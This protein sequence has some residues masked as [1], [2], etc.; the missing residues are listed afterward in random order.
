MPAAPANDVSVDSVV[1]ALVREHLTN[2]EFTSTLT[3][4][5]QEQPTVQ[6]PINKRSILHDVLGLT[7]AQSAPQSRHKPSTLDVLVQQHLL[8][9]QHAP[10]AP[11]SSSKTQPHAAGGL[12]FQNQALATKQQPPTVSE[13]STQQQQ[14]QTWHR[15]LPAMTQ[16]QNVPAQTPHQPPGSSRP[17]G[18]RMQPPRSSR[19]STASTAAYDSA[20]A[21]Q[22]LEELVV[23]DVDFDDSDTAAVASTSTT[24]AR[25]T[26]RVLQ[27]FQPLPPEQQRQLAQ[28]VW[29]EP[30]VQPEAAWQQG[31]I[32]NDAPGLEWGLLQLSGGPCGVLAA[33][34]AHLIATL[35]EQH[36]W[37]PTNPAAPPANGSSS[38]GGAGAS[39]AGAGAR[40]TAEQ[41]Q[42]ALT[43]SLVLMLWTCATTSSNSSSSGGRRSGPAAHVVVLQQSAAGSAGV[44][45][46][47]DVGQVLLMVQVATANS[48]AE[49]E[50]LVRAALP[51]WCARKG[52]GLLLLVYSALLSRGCHCAASDMDNEAYL[53]RYPAV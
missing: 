27:D 42:A 20:S 17:L 53:H 10:D 26:G 21:T 7:A 25:S 30:G 48:M 5:Q 24:A 28:L 23:C 4:W 29:G 41:L 37:R 9:K 3:A 52:W 16:Q 35:M 6:H 51:Q 2:R 13:C 1:E 44:R 18:S 50:V 8:R 40:P 32:W 14:E 49:L 46:L 36:L 15:R 22:Q 19:A 38:S 34:Q 11:T 31:L 33:V 45:G 39:G 43:S 47:C 12:T